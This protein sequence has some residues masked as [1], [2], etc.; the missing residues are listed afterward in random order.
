MEQVV[1]DLALEV[2]DWAEVFAE[3]TNMPA[4]LN[5]MCAIASAELWKRLRA[6][7]IKA[8]ICMSE[9]DFG[10]HVYLKVEDHVVDVTATQ[11]SWSKNEPVLIRHER[12]MEHREYY[13]NPVF[14]VD[15]SMLRKHQINTGWPKSQVAR[16]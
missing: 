5:G 14:F 9:E 16:K 6:H 7:G 3:K 13:R 2:R 1:R 8:K 12:E 10:F 11:F 15:A 4:N